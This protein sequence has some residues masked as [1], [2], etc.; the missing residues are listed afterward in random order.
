MKTLII[1]GPPRSGTTG[2]CQLINKSE[3]AFVSNELYTFH[4]NEELLNTRICRPN[5]ETLEALQNKKWD[6]SQLREMIRSDTYPSGLEIFGDKL[7]AYC[8]DRHAAK[9][10]VD[11]YGKKA[12]FIFTTRKIHG[13]VNSFIK[14]SKIQKKHIEAIWYFKNINISLETIIRY[15]DNL[16][17]MY[18]KIKNK[19]IVNYDDA[20][21]D[22][23]YIQNKL[24]SF[25]E[26]QID[27]NYYKNDRFDDWKIDLNQ[28]Q[29]NTIDDFLDNYKDI[30]EVLPF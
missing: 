11:K 27:S 26:I 7:P 21:Q 22:Q 3:K 14:R 13:I 23:N 5:A 24:E 9:H 8:L 28:E 1:C 25:L 18:P 4:P 2:L 15:Y 19:T 10:L 29:K 30:N 6:I 16:L 20:M 17:F 12:H